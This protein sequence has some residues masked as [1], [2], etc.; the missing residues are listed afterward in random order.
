MNQP[1]SS[2]YQKRHY[3]MPPHTSC[4]GNTRNCLQYLAAKPFH[5][6][7]RGYNIM[8]TRAVEA[9]MVPKRRLDSRY[10]FIVSV[11]RIDATK[12]Y[13]YLFL[14]LGTFLYAYFYTY[15]FI[16]FN[17]AR[18]I[19]FQLESNIANISLPV[20]RRSFLLHQTDTK[21]HLPHVQFI[22]HKIVHHSIAIKTQKK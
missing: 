20:Q 10:T 18:K 14:Y 19:S 17:I 8:S 16:E 9:S 11:S 3:L 12:I 13:S 22:I 7:Y 21:L 5:R 15:K 4:L 1:I 2:N 6:F